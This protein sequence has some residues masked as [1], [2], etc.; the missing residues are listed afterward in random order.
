[1][2]KEWTNVQ[3]QP[4]KP[5]KKITICTPIPLNCSLM[6][7]DAAWRAAS[8]LAGL[9]WTI[10]REG[11]EVSSFS[12]D[13]SVKSALVAKAMAMRQAVKESWIL[14]HKRLRCE[15]DSDQLIKAF[16]GNE[17]PLEI[18]GIVADILDYSFRFEVIAFVWIPREKNSIADGLAKQGLVM[19]EALMANT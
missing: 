15:A 19:V 13:S 2:A 11:E 3:E 9:G 16:N 7:S 12:T 14:G 6:R 1:M 17:V 4:V 5:Q 18:Y 8:Q 10:R